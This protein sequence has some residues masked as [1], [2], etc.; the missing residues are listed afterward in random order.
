MLDECEKKGTCDILAAHHELLKDDD[1]RLKTDVMLKFVCKNE[2][3]D[4]WNKL[5]NNMNVKLESEKLKL[6]KSTVKPNEY[7]NGEGQEDYHG[8]QLRN[9]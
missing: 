1:E 5:L 2:Y 4:M 7:E 3:D 8:T 9:P 6:K